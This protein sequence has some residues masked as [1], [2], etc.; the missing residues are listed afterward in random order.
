MNTGLGLSESQLSIIRMRQMSKIKFEPQSD[1]VSTL[2]GEKYLY[3]TWN[4]GIKMKSLKAIWEG[5]M[6]SGRINH[7]Y[8]MWAGNKVSLKCAMN[9][10]IIYIEVIGCKWGGD[11]DIGAVITS[12][13]EV[14]CGKA[15][16][17][18]SIVEELR[19]NME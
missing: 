5:E 11:T 19:R 17:G 15:V 6:T 7:D 8:W 16:R 10:S 9:G 18:Q 12:L 4:K 2:I 13:A 14:H 1:S 3:Q